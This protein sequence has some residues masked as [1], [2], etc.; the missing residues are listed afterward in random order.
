MVVLVE[1]EQSGSTPGERTWARTRTE[2]T[3][4]SLSSLV[5]TNSGVRLVQHSG[6]ITTYVCRGTERTTKKELQDAV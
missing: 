3:F 6:R 5:S 2:L 1:D 4:F